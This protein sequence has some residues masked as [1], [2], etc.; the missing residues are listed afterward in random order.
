ML[1]NF[2]FKRKIGTLVIVAVVGLCASMVVSFVQLRKSIL[3]GRQSALVTAVQSAR[4]IAVGYQ[5]MAARHVLSDAAAQQAAKDALRTVRFGDTGTDYVYVY[6]KGGKGVMHPIKKEWEG[7]QLFGKVIDP[8]GLDVVKAI[9]EASNNSPDGTGFVSMMFPRPGKTQPVPKLQYVAPVPGWDWVVGSGVYMDEVD[10]QVRSALLSGMAV[11]VLLLVVIGS[12]GW[13]ISRSVL[14]QIG[15]DPV[16]AA[17]AVNQVASGNL[18]VEVGDAP[19]G[20]LLHSL[21]LMIASLR[22]T[23]T[24]VRHVTDSISVASGEIAGGNHDLSVR[25]EQAA[26][27]L[28]ETA[29]SMEQLTGTVA[30]T[31]DS[32]RKARDLA[33]AASAAAADGGAIVEQVISTM[34]DISDSSKRIEDII[35]VID[36]IAFQTNILA[37]NAAVEAARAGE[38]GRGFAVVAEEVRSLARRSAEAAKEIKS[39]ISNSVDRV[40]SGASLVGR[41]GASMGEIVARVD[42]VSVIISEITEATTEQSSGI[43]QINGAVSHLDQMTQQNAALVEQSAAAAESLKEQAQRLASVVEVFRLAA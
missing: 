21:G 26:S 31:S 36:G 11:A 35:G 4:S 13:A 15:G 40:E 19:T 39:L 10:L 14:G 1:N 6:T 24:N 33:S 23:V 8:T 17:R 9:V 42:R 2:S 37:L 7:Q 12:I 30:Q 41:A 18:A 29:A 25:T 20:S 38:Q 27:S 3:E 22:Q 5:Q 34:R 32:A 16:D 43:G 28:Q